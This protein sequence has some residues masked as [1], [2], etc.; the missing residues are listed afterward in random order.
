MIFSV[1]WDLETI[2]FPGWNPGDP[3]QNSAFSWGWAGNGVRL[4]AGSGTSQE[5]ELKQHGQGA[6]MLGFP[7]DSKPPTK[8][9]V[10]SWNMGVSP[11]FVSCHFFGKFLPLFPMIFWR[12]GGK[13]LDSFYTQIIRLSLVGGLNFC[14]PPF[15][16][17]N[18][19]HNSGIDQ[20]VTWSMTGVAGVLKQANMCFFFG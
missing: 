3:H 4:D 9:W 8:S 5:A 1:D 11:R 12:N 16:F 6:E 15:A 10:F 2:Y 7:W 20:L 14:W 18:V 13:Q 19:Q 17:C